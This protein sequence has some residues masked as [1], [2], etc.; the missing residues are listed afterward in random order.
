MA[1][2]RG[3]VKDTRDPSRR[4]PRWRSRALGPDQSRSATSWERA[5]V[6]PNHVP[7]PWPLQSGQCHRRRRPPIKAYYVALMGPQAGEAFAALMQDAAG[8]HLKYTSPLHS[9]PAARSDRRAEQG[10]SGLPLPGLRGVVE[11]PHPAQ[12]S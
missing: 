5:A 9:S 6:A 12:L 11:R 4:P 2:T 1:L 8:L 10:R 7:M 3:R